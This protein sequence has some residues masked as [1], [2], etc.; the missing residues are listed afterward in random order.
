MSLLLP[1]DYEYLQATDLHFL[2]DEEKRFFVIENFPLPERMYVLSS[3]ETILQAEVLIQVP[4]NY[5]MSGTDMLW[6]YPPFI[7]AD[8]GPM[9]NVNSYG[10]SDNRTFKEKEFCRWSRHY[11]GDSWKAKKDGIE[12]ILARIDWALRNPGA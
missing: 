7:R 2:E 6:T 9:P 12:K 10:G 3:G 5:N 11:A 4:N 8:N 1:E